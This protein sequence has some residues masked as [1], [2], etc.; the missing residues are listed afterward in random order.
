MALGE[1]FLSVLSAAQE[2][3]EWAWRI[4]Y[5]ELAGQVRGYLRTRGARDPDD[6]LG[7]VFLQIARNLGGFSGGEAAFRSWVFMIA[8]HRVID[9]RRARNRRPESLVPADELRYLE[10][11]DDVEDEAM[12]GL[13]QQRVDE[14]LERLT[15]EQQDVVALRVIGQLSLAEAAEVLGK[16]VGAVKAL[17]HRAFLVLREALDEERAT[18]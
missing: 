8:H 9:E 14:L 1:Q 6:L 18:F 10:A 7:E 4:L 15:T 13:S 12:A 16:T 3:S 11:H 2:G 17:Q 5:D